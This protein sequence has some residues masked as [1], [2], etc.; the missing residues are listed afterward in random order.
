[1]PD[2]EQDARREM[3]LRLAAAFSDFRHSLNNSL[4]VIMALAEMAQ[5]DPARSE[6]LASSVLEKGASIMEKLREF[7]ADFNEALRPER[8]EQ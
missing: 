4:A 8:R 2:P 7:T 1:M 6:R 3:E 5:R